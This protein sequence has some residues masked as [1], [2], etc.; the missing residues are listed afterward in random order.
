L[1]ESRDYTRLYA[2]ERLPSNIARELINWLSDLHSLSF[3]GSMR[4]TLTNREMRELNHEHL[5]RFPLD[6]DNGFDLDA[7]TAG[8]REAASE[9]A[10]DAVY[11]DR[12]TA[13]GDAYLSDGRVL[14]H[15]DFFPGSWLDTGD[16]PA[17]IDPEFAFFGT[18]E[19]DMGVL[20]GHLHLSRQPDAVHA[21]VRE[22]Y[23]PPPGFDWRLAEAFAGVE[24]M[25]R[26]IGVAQLPLPIG[27]EEKRT[28]LAKSRQLVVGEE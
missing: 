6:R 8:L 4:A 25:R 23:R 19:F 11:V 5:F 28:L 12:V 9:L 13:L 15:G 22:G 20:L 3:D 14:L 21:S 26:L 17:V 10:S 16:G 24:I 18:P 1:G 7:I 2:G 27:L